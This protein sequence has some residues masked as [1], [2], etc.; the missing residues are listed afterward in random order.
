VVEAG[1]E[2]D[3]ALGGA[4]SQRP[5]DREPKFADDAVRV[6]LLDVLFSARAAAGV[7]CRRPSRDQIGDPREPLDHVGRSV[8]LLG[9]T[10]DAVRLSL[11]AFARQPSEWP[12]G[13]FM[14]A[15]T[16]N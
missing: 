8:E 12:A 5:P 6:G 9:A 3:G 2:T 14:K 15:V 7:A 1:D 4:G 16:S 13:D 10:R 11:R